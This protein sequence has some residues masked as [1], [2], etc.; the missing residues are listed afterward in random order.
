MNDM[1][2]V[3][4]DR[5]VFCRLKSNGRLVITKFNRSKMS[6]EVI[7]DEIYLYDKKDFSGWFEMFHQSDE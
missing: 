6:F 7:R 4:L 1:R 2:S 5:Q 3:P